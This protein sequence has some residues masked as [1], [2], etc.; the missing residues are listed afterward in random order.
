MDECKAMDRDVNMG[1]IAH[2]IKVLPQKKSIRLFYTGC[3]HV[4][5]KA[6]Y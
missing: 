3:K 1:R 5:F 4:L 2:F 6:Y